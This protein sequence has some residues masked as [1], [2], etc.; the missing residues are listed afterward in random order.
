MAISSIDVHELRSEQNGFWS[1]EG[2]TLH[3]FRIEKVFN[4]GISMKLLIYLKIKLFHEFEMKFASCYLHQWFIMFY[5]LSAFNLMNF[6]YELYKLDHNIP[7]ENI[8]CFVVVQ[9][10]F[11]ITH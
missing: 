3:F 7:F 2:F 6:T 10:T 5:A 1:G 8:C 11:Y 9:T 4:E